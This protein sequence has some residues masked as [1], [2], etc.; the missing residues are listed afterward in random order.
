[1]KLFDN[2]MAAC[3]ERFGDGQVQKIAEGQIL[4]LVNGKIASVA[5][6]D[7]EVIENLAERMSAA[8]FI[9]VF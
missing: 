7:E 8:S 5:N 2:V 4:G 1:M 6:S 3:C 9:T